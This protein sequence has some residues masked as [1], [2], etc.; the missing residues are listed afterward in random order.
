MRLARPRVVITGGPGVGKTTLLNELAARGFAT[1]PESAREVLRERRA[2]GLPMRPPP[3]V[4]A[5]E[6]LRRDAARCADPAPPGP[7]V[8]FDRCVVESVAM[9]REC[10]LLTADQAAAALR[11]V[12][13]HRRVFVLPPWPAIYVTDA[14]RDHSFGHCQRVHRALMRAYLSLGVKIHEV[15]WDAPPRRA[16]HLLAVLAAE[17]D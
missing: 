9:A 13:F 5:A 14:E 1:V 7:P 11:G 2:Q 15:P 17:A 8:F 10:D 6:L 12:D 4:F 3:P 16:A